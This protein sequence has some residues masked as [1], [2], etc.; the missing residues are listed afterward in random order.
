MKVQLVPTIQCPILVLASQNIP[1]GLAKERKTRWCWETDSCTA[2]TPTWSVSIIIIITIIMLSSQSDNLTACLCL[3]LWTSW[4]WQWQRCCCPWHQMDQRGCSLHW[5]PLWWC[6]CIM[7]IWIRDQ[8]QWKCF[9]GANISGISKFPYLFCC[10]CLDISKRILDSSKSKITQGQVTIQPANISRIFQ[11][12][13]HQKRDSDGKPQILHQQW[14]HTIYIITANNARCAAVLISDFC[15]FS[16]A[17]SVVAGK[18]VHGQT[19]GLLEAEGPANKTEPHPAKCFCGWH[20]PGEL[21]DCQTS[22]EQPC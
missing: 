10:L 6:K 7:V 14:T 21:F 4:L 1:V 13:E 15:L 9:S 12:P 2:P 5:Q 20:P 18:L 8:D 16:L 22:A 19:R 3:M 17:P 11:R